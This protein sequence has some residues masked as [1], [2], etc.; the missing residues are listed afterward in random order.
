MVDYK[1]QLHQFQEEIDYFELHQQELL[2]RFPDKWV[3]IYQQRVVGASP[4]V[5]HLLDC[6]EEQAVPIDQALIRH[7]S[8]NEDVLILVR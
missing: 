3:A 1:S 2:D 6:L 7:L 5:H 4:D 8:V